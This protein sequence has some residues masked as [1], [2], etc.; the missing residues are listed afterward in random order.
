MNYHRK[1]T[2]S[3]SKHFSKTEVLF[4]HYDTLETL[5]NLSISFRFI[6][7]HN[8]TC[9]LARPGNVSQYISVHKA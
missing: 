5:P 2:C 9:N 6:L 3:I 4:E 8:R 7:A 1:T